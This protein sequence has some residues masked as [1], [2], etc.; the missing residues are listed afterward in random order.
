MNRKFIIGFVI[1]GLL[2]IIPGFALGVYL[3]PIWVAS[4]GATEI[5][6]AE[7]VRQSVRKGEFRRDLKGSDFGHWGEG[8]II[9][10]MEGG[11]TYFTLKGEV[12]PGPDYKLYLAPRFV[13]TEAEFEAIK[14]DS[15]R[16]ADITAFENFRVAV[17]MKVNVDAYPVVVVWCER[18]REFITAARLH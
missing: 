5:E 3:L 15:V 11:Q 9:Q 14:D 4:E 7:A 10:S 12:S 16:V 13:E 6:R 17:P 8:T 1:G 18:F 2:G